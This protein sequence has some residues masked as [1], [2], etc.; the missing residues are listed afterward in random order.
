MNCAF[1]CLGQEYSILWKTNTVN[2]VFED[3][4]LNSASLGSISSDMQYCFQGWGADAIIKLRNKEGSVGYMDYG[5]VNPYYPDGLAFPKNLITNETAGIALQVS[6]E[7]SDA[8]TNAMAFAAANTGIVAT[9]YEFIEFVS[10]TNFYSVS[11]NQIANYVLFRDATPSIYLQFFVDIT[12][13]L[14]KQKYYLPSLLGFCYSSE[15]PG[16]TNLWL[17]IPSTSTTMTGE[18]QWSPFPA[19]WH[20]G[21]WKFSFWDA[22]E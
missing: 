13:S 18:T 5:T 10:S 11:S 1:A 8:Y 19:I 22:Q 20:E 16:T 6:K 12:N 17:N 21:K 7:I 14:R 2:V 15:G 3:S 9:A 4:N